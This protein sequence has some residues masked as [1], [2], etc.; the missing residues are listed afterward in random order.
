ML[1]ISKYSKRWQLWNPVWFRIRRIPCRNPYNYI[2]SRWYPPPYK[3]YTVYIT[4]V[5]RPLLWWLFSVDWSG[6]QGPD[7]GNSVFSS[8]TCSTFDSKAPNTKRMLQDWQDSPIT[9]AMITEPSSQEG[10]EA[11]LAYHLRSRDLFWD[12]LISTNSFKAW[13]QTCC[14][15][16]SQEPSEFFGIKQIT[17]ESGY[18]R[19]HVINGGIVFFHRN[20]HHTIQ[21][22]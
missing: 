12:V 22:V 8:L 10:E 20:Q 19:L 16:C 9:V 7:W 15:L 18:T 21:V 17:T 1:Q 11:L 2:T 5:N 14:C 13:Y 4:S 6:T 3:L